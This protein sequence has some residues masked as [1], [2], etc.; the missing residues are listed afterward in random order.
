MPIHTKEIRQ[1]L[2][3]FEGKQ[4][5]KGYI[6]CDLTTGKTA[7]YYGGANP[8]RYIP[9]GVSGVTIGTGVDLGQTDEPTLRRIGVSDKTIDA[10]R[11][12]LQ[13]TKIKAV[14]ALHEKPLTITPEMAEELDACMHNQH[15]EIT[16]KRYN[17]DAGEGA[18]EELPWQAQAVITSI[19][20]QRGPG[21]IKKFENTWNAFV[22]KDWKDASARLQNSSLWKGYQSRRREEG[23][24]LDTI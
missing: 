4:V 17:R 20:Y 1:V 12:Y 14:Y 10:V 7:N 11:F 16:R 19:I 5:T 24:I 22:R 2:T 23:K 8:E 13:K 18:F 9:M 21:S 6:P 3:K 15:I